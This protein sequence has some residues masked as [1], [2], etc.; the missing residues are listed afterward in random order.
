VALQGDMLML[1]L[2]SP[3]KSLV[4]MAVGT[5]VRQREPPS[6]LNQHINRGGDSDNGFGKRANY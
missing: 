3:S 1:M 2:T 5:V 6:T 4:N